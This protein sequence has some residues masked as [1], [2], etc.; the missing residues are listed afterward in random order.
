MTESITQTLE[1]IQETVENVGQINESVSN[2]ARDSIEICDN[3]QVVETAMK[4]V[5]S[6]NKNMVDN[7]QQV[8]S[9]ME[10]MTERINTSNDASRM[11]LNKYE[12]SARNVDKIEN[13]VSKLMV[14]LGDGGFMGIKDVNRGMK[15][16]LIPEDDDSQKEYH[17]EVI[18]Q[19]EDDVW[20]KLDGEDAGVLGKS[21]IVTFRAVVNNAVYCWT[22]TKAQ[23]DRA[24][25]NNCYHL[26]ISQ[27]PSVMN[28]RKYARMPIS[29]S[30]E[31]RM[32]VS[33]AIFTAK[34]VNISAGGFA[35][36]V[37]NEVFASSIGKMITVTI[38]DFAVESARVM[39]GVIIRSTK[40]DNEYI[41]GCRLLDDNMD[42]KEYVEQNYVER[43]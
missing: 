26:N 22:S 38:E 4:E 23:R 5:E 31:I 8:C 40:N 29:N 12:E 20:I 25:G 9:V 33:G 16:V 42:V 28:R 1:L 2:I 13:V 34:M 35:F 21:K 43:I 14:E 11:M 37:F 41:V 17:G 24:Y 10:M 30:C 6:S 19:E 32:D 39:K 18:E 3:V 27:N 15:V 7:M 36:K